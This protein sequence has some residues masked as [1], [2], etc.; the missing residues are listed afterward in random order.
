MKKLLSIFASFGLIT[1][2]IPTV[3]GFQ[4]QHNNIS[5]QENQIK[6]NVLIEDENKDKITTF[7][8]E[9]PFKTLGEVMQDD[10]DHYLLKDYGEPLGLY[11]Y[12]VSYYINDN[13]Q[14]ILEDPSN[15]FWGLYWI[16]NNGKEIFSDVGM[17]S[18]YFAQKSQQ[19]IW[20][21]TKL[22]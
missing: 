12:G 19:I 20:R 9:T 1:S 8:Y 18:F 17:S 11:L 16:D 5:L 7:N 2:I 21:L 13:K 4:T 10:F 22:W 6:I 3:V 14:T 15:N